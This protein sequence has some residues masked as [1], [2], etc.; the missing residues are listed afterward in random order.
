MIPRLVLVPAFGGWALCCKSSL[1]GHFFALCVGHKLEQLDDQTLLRAAVYKH[2]LVI[3]D[4]SD[5][6][7]IAISNKYEVGSRLVKT[8]GTGKRTLHQ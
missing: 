3:R 1:P 5:L 4:L 7:T 6:A 8:R 2:L